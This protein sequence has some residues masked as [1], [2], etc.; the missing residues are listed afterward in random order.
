MVTSDRLLRFITHLQNDR[1]I[2]HGRRMLLKFI[3]E[4]YAAPVAAL[5][6]LDR[7]RQLLALLAYSGRYPSHETASLL[8]QQPISRLDLRHIPLDGLFG[9]T[10]HTQGLSS[11]PNLFADPRTIP[12]ERAWCL[13]GGRA[14]LCPIKSGSQQDSLQGL[15][16]VCFDPDEKEPETLNHQG[17]ALICM[18]LLS[19]YL[20]RTDHPA[21]SDP[22]PV[23]PQ[24]ENQSSEEMPPTT[25]HQKP[26]RLAK[27]PARSVTLPELLYSLSNLSM[28]YEIGLIAGTASEIQEIYQQILTHMRHVISS[29]AACLLLYH[30]IQHRF[31]S[32]A[33]QG[34][35]LSGGS[36]AS[37]IDHRE[38]EQQAARGPGET[39]SVIRTETFRVLL[40]TLSHG[41]MLIGVIALTI[42]NE[43]DLY[44]ERGLLL[45]YLGNVAA[46]ILRDYEIQSVAQKELIE[47]ERSRI[48]RD[49]HDGPTQQ[50]AHALH[51]LELIR[52]MLE[53]QPPQ[54]ALAEVERVHSILLDS[55]NG[56]RHNI[57]SLLPLQVKEH[58]FMAALQRLVDECALHDSRV[59]ITYN[60]DEPHLLPSS[61]ETPIFRFVQEALNNILKHAGAT[62]ITIQIRLFTDTL[63]VEVRDN[64]VGFLLEQVGSRTSRN[65]GACDSAEH[66]GLR[67]MRERV[68]EAGG[69][70][71]IQSHPGHGTTVKARFPL[72]R[73][74]P[75]LTQ[76]EREVLRLIIEGQ[77]NRQ[78]AQQLTISAETVKTH[79]HHIMQKMQVK[80]RTQAAVLA[81]RHGWL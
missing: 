25:T 39:L 8:S 54:Q 36:I 35:E 49:L 43:N 58:G 27:R 73:P 44:S 59:R 79:I 15:L 55:L 7:E 2:T 21:V 65:Q 34:E 41:G 42:P 47:Q 23:Q 52:H 13:P 57:S 75:H 3:R 32:V 4:S 70:W 33:S 17:D 12:P 78:I 30:P 19:A 48:A 61:L 29:S 1:S 56:L 18:T 76:R 81:S 66:I 16:L 50:I 71:E 77:S 68:Q 45:T 60:I 11:I 46:L 67:S 10:L 6:L 72:A 38:M 28:L 5:F 37:S 40:V 26:A 9:A 24:S 64:G 14:L 80:D 20:S 63:V 69:S 53:N 31:F 74:A 51:K 22:A 62:Q